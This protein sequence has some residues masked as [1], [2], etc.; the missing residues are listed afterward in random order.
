M[1]PG[2]IG[3]VDPPGIFFAL[4]A[5]RLGFSAFGEDRNLT[6]LALLAA[7][8]LRGKGLSPLSLAGKGAGGLGSPRNSP[9]GLT[10]TF[11]PASSSFFFTSSAVFL[12]TAVLIGF[13]APST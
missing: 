2:R 7:P 11:P 13:G 4:Y 3:F 5:F 6:P 8:S 12:S 1:I 10:V 9:A